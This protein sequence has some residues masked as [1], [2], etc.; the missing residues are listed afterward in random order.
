MISLLANPSQVGSH[1]FSTDMS[2]GKVAVP[3]QGIYSCGFLA[4]RERRRSVLP[5]DESHLILLL[6]TTG[7]LL[8]RCGKDG[9]EVRKMWLSCCLEVL[10]FQGLAMGQA[11]G[12]SS[13]PLPCSWQPL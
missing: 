1:P 12:G 6:R 4:W 2:L 8:Q 3:S 9:W 11:G 5:A 10:C 13:T 7:L